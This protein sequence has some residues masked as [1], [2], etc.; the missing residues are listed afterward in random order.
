MD[1][2]D[3]TRLHRIYNLG[4]SSPVTLKQFISIVEDAVGKKANKRLLP[5][6]PG[7]VD[8]TYAD[9]SLSMKELRYQPQVP[10]EEGV[11]RLV[12]WYRETKL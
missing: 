3:E 5:D 9:I 8:C 2:G 4:N 10:L 11:R 12:A 1:M 7:D 6:Q